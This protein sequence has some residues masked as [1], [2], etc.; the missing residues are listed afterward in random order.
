MDVG[1]LMNAI[2]EISWHSLTVDPSIDDVSRAHA[3]EIR[4]RLDGSSGKKKI[5]F[6]EVGAYARIHP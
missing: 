4:A 1:H 3:D 6:L 5:R 2:G